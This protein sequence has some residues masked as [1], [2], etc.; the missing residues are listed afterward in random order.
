M[1]LVLEIVADIWLKKREGFVWFCKGLLFFG[2]SVKCGGHFQCFS[3]LCMKRR[4]PFGLRDIAR[5]RYTLCMFLRNEP[6]DIF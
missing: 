4:E 6:L 2:G 3:S 1:V 5:K